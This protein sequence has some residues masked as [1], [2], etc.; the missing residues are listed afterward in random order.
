MS[1]NMSQ[2]ALAGNG[3]RLIGSLPKLE[4]RGVRVLT[5]EMLAAVYGTEDVRIRNN[6]T[7]NRG[8]FR[9]GVHF[10][11]VTGDDLRAIKTEYLKDTLFG[12]GATA[13]SAVLWTARGTARHAKM[14]E[15]DE[16]WAMF[17]KLED[18]YFS[19][20]P[21]DVA[22]LKLQLEQRRMDLA[23]RRLQVQ[24]INAARNTFLAFSR[25]G[26]KAQLAN[27]PEIFAKVGMK[28]DLSMSAVFEQGDLFNTD[29]SDG[30]PDQDKGGGHF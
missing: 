29:E 24:E 7:R 10:F 21:A 26:V 22:D 5:T 1:E 18:A 30:E 13:R 3:D 11:K 16:A 9:E 23:S 17:E 27:A 19:R 2:M 12:I 6:H 15:T 14:L 28:I 20:S 4:Y 25:A 8:R